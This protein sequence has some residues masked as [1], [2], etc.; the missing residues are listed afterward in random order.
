MFIKIN[1]WLS[2]PFVKLEFNI[3]S[4]FEKVINQK[5]TNVNTIIE[6]G[7]VSR[8]VLEKNNC[9]RYIGIDIDSNFNHNYFYDVFYCKSVEENLP[10]NADLI[11]SKYLMEHI[12][13][14]EIS[15]LNQIA[16]LNSGGTIVHLYPLGYHPFSL[17]NKLV[18]NDLARSIIPIIRKGSETVTG[19]PAFYKL[20]NAYKL[21]KFLSKINGI[22]FK[23]RYHYG[24]LDYFSFFF[25]FAIIILIFNTLSSLLNLKIF[26][27]NVLVEIKKN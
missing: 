21:E 2:K 10:E 1:Q 3:D 26:A 13:N 8:P 14:V 18:G 22:D 17:L 4:Y 19:Y 23:V 27:S 5:A 7:G 9:Y 20:G 15:Y 6:L 12:E 25:P 24:A 16:A 11:F